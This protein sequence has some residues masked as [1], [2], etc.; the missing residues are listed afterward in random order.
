MPVTDIQVDIVTAMY[1]PESW[2][3]LVTMWDSHL[4]LSM[5][6]VPGGFLPLG[7]NECVSVGALYTLG[8]FLPYA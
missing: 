1:V 7:V 5:H 4:S 8:V 2:I 6:R 3:N